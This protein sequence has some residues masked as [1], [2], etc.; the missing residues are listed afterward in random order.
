M[1]VLKTTNWLCP[2]SPAPQSPR[3]VCEIALQILPVLTPRFPIN[4]RCGVAS[5]QITSS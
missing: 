1:N 5:I 4:S 2:I 3:E